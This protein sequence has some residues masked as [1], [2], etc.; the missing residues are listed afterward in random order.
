MSTSKQIRTEQNI[1]VN[2]GRIESICGY[3]MEINYFNG[4]A[5]AS[6]SLYNDSHFMGG[7]NQTSMMV[8]NLPNHLRLIANELM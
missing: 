5:Y 2:F 6:Y 7:I 3:I 1:K 8:E 4:I